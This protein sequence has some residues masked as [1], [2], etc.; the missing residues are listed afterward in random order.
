MVSTP[1]IVFTICIS[2]ST[3]AVVSTP[4]IVITICISGRTLAVSADTS[5]VVNT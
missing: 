2:G 1:E 4:E 5:E 3:I